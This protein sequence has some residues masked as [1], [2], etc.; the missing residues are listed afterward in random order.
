MT[1]VFIMANVSFS[2]AFIMLGEIADRK[3]LRLISAGCNIV[4]GMFIGNAILAAIG[5]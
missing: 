2:L 4:S 5:W 3:K 1:T